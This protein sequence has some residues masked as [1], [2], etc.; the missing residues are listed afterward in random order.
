MSLIHPYPDWSGW[1][2]LAFRVYLDEPDALQVNVVDRDHDETYEDRFN[3]SYDL[4]AGWSE[5]EIP[6]DAVVKG[7]AK[8]ALDLERVDAVTW[9]LLD[10]EHPRTIRLDDVRLVK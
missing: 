7:P 2:A 1:R 3:G 8:R 5:V 4:P 6:L 9:F 10:V